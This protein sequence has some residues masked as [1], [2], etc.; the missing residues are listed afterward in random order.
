EKRRN[1]EACSCADARR[2][3]GLAPAHPSVSKALFA[4]CGLKDRNEPRGFTAHQICEWFWSTPARLDQGGAEFS[5]PLFDRLLVEA[6][7]ERRGELLDHWFWRPGG[8]EYGVLHGNVEF[9][10]T[11]FVGRRHIRQHRAALSGGNR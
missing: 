8:G 5:E 9:A 2:L 1:S 6:L 10:K 11:L 7:V 3:A 4:R